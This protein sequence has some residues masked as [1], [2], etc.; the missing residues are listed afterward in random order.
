MLLQV[1]VCWDTFARPGRLE[2]A[3]AQKIAS[4][5][6]GALGPDLAQLLVRTVFFFKPGV[7]F[8]LQNICIVRAKCPQRVLTGPHKE[9]VFIGN[10]DHRHSRIIGIT[11]LAIWVDVCQYLAGKLFLSVN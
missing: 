7:E 9:A 10:F 5:L 1:P 6:L 2:V 4:E 3:V 8:F 11:D